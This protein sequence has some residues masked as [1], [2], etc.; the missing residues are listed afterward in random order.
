MNEWMNELKI[1]MFIYR[2][3]YEE[4]SQCGAALYK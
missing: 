1:K 2:W 4:K 3:T